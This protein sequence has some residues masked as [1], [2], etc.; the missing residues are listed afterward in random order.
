MAWYHGIADPNRPADG[1]PV[2][3]LA[4]STNAAEGVEALAEALRSAGYPP[5]L[6]LWVDGEFVGVCAAA[7]IQVEIDVGYRYGGSESA[8]APGRGRPRLTRYVCPEPACGRQAYVALRRFALCHD[9]DPSVPMR[10][11]TS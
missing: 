7:D 4:A 2:V 8:W 1:L 10:E 3:H 11:A 6:A 9:H 5:G